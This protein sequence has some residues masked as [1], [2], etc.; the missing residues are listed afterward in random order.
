[1]L[2]QPDPL[3]PDDEDE[4]QPAAA[5]RREQ[6]GD[7]PAVKALMRNSDRSN[8]G[9]ATRVSITPNA[10]STTTP[11]PMRPST[12]GLVQPMVCPA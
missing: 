6:V 5:Q 1:V 2:G 9:S 10:T 12:V 4:L 8:M 7:V 11:P 3:Q